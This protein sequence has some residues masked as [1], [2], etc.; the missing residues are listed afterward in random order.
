MLPALSVFSKSDDYFQIQFQLLLGNNCTLV[1]QRKSA[2]KSGFTGTIAFFP[3][4]LSTLWR[5]SRPR[6]EHIVWYVYGRDRWCFPVIRCYL[7]SLY[8]WYDASHFVLYRSASYPYCIIS[9]HTGPVEVRQRYPPAN[10]ALHPLPLMPHLPHHLQAVW[11]RCTQLAVTENPSASLWVWIGGKGRFSILNGYSAAI[12]GG[13]LSKNGRGCKHLLWQLA[14]TQYKAQ[15]SCTLCFLGKYTHTRARRHTHTSHISWQGKQ[16]QREALTSCCKNPSNKF[17][18]LL[19]KFEAF[20]LKKKGQIR[21]TEEEEEKKKSSWRK[22]HVLS[23]FLIE[24]VVSA[25]CIQIWTFDAG[26]TEWHIDSQQV[27]LFPYQESSSSTFFTIIPS[28]LCQLYGLRT[29]Q[30]CNAEK[31]RINC[32]GAGVILSLHAA[33][34]ICSKK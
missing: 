13:Y 6:A 23:S 27:R 1:G 33:K 7:C 8:V 3:A 10:P 31:W 9:D 14:P 28:T 19:Q 24:L 20:F 32:Q 12:Q 26:Q 21:K 17:T 11:R 30:V 18:L 5:W 34:W 25:A 22:S 4:L 2:V 29:E 16:R 15:H